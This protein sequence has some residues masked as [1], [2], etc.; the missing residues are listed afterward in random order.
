MVPLSPKIDEK[1]KGGMNTQISL[2]GVKFCNGFINKHWSSADGASSLVPSA[3]WGGARTGGG[4]RGGVSS[5]GAAGPV[6]PRTSPSPPAPPP[7][8]GRARL[9]ASVGERR[10]PLALDSVCSAGGVRTQ[11]PAGA[12]LGALTGPAGPGPGP[13]RTEGPE[14]PPGPAADQVGTRGRV[15][16]GTLV[17]RPVP[18]SRPELGPRAGRLGSDPWFQP[19]LG[20]GDR[21]SSLEGGWRY[22]SHGFRICETGSSQRQPNGAVGRI[23]EVAGEKSVRHTVGG[24]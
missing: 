4:G 15:V 19:S 2:T 24:Q 14:R 22:T 6:P 20:R 1:N 13:G 3:G 5:C 10:S 8:A 11:V 21:S 7:R 18:G 12:E 9:L 23:L 16:P 17:R